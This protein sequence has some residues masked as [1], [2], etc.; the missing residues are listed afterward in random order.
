VTVSSPSKRWELRPLE[1]A[2]WQQ[3]GE[4]R[5]NNVPSHAWDGDFKPGFRKQAEEAV[6]AALKEIPETLP[7]LD[8]VLK[9]M[10]LVQAIYRMEV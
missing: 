9:T 3:R 10:R 6:K 7:T 5:L 4:R 2:A 8:D 1:Q